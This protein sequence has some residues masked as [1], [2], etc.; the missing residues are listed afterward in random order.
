M[1]GP[2]NWLIQRYHCGKVLGI[3]FI[4]WSITMLGTTGVQNYQGLFACR[5]LLGIFEAATVSALTLTTARFYTPVEQPA[6]FAIWSLGNNITPI[7]F[8]LI[9]F[10]LGQTPT[11]NNGT[12][13]PWR[14]F[15]ILL[16]GLTLVFGIY[17]YFLF[18]DRP[19]TWRCYTPRQRAIAVVRIARTQVG[20]KNHHYKVH[21]LKEA[22]SDI[23]VWL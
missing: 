23:K 17:V 10:G 18:P 16:G 11:L 15:F 14:W 4:C 21:Q 1:P 12:F 2:F 9:F 20:V 8:L 3:A 7:P 6:R 5:F 22:L 13:A 19:D